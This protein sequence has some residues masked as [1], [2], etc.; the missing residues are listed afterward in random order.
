MNKVD[1]EKL[2]NFL[3]VDKKIRKI[4]DRIDYVNNLLNM[5]F[6][7]LSQVIEY[8]KDI[9]CKCK[10][11][12]CNNRKIFNYNRADRTEYGF[13]D[14]CSPKCY[15]KY[16]SNRQLGSNNSSHK[17]SIESF[18]SMRSKNSIIMKDKIKSG[19]FKPN[20]TNSWAKSRVS[21]ILNDVKIT[22][23]SSWDAFFNLVNPNL[24]YEKII[25][26]YIHD[27]MRYNYIVDFVDYENKIIYEIKPSGFKDFNKN[28]SKEKYAIEWCRVNNYRYYMIDEKWY[29]EN[30]T[31]YK[32]LLDD[33]PE[34]D[35]IKRKL[36]Q[37]DE[38]KK[39]K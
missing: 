33:Q 31:R 7:D 28:I 25:I 38:D 15:N 12:G 11:D 19:L 1:K 21:L 16:L 32:Y 5:N 17:M 37:F 29:I 36:R 9:N 20:I 10:L 30:Y 23:R 39:N 3:F 14:Y 26:E 13:Y 27:G 22:Y 8:L 4:K 18:N 6:T 34:G 24:L 35:E 2:Y